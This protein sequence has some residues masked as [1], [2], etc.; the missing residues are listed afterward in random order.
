MTFY[1]FMIKL[2]RSPKLIPILERMKS[3]LMLRKD[4]CATDRFLWKEEQ[5]GGFTLIELL[6]VVAIIGILAAIAVPN[7]LNA[8]TRAKV[9]GTVSD[10]RN[11]GV[12]IESYRIDNNNPPRTYTEGCY[13]GTCVGTQFSRYRRFV[14]LTTPVSYMSSIPKDKFYKTGYDFDT[15][16]DPVKTYPYWEPVMADTYRTPAGLGLH[17]PDQAKPNKMW[18]LMS[19]G[20]DGDFEA[21]ASGDL[22]PFEAS[23][24]LNSNGDIMR[25]GN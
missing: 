7:F 17:F 24:G 14:Q 2:V 18:A 19:Y 25:F 10:M 6:I 3:I 13:S 23:N 1:D 22:A 12:A 20:P 9:A 8:Q 5:T 11:I 16:T 4:F 15:S 21:A